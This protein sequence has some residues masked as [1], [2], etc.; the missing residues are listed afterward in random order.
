MNIAAAMAAARAA[1]AS[2][3]PRHRAV[4]RALHHLLAAVGVAQRRELARIER[5]LGL[6]ARGS[7]PQRLGRALAAALQREQRT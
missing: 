5:E 6:R 4:L 1:A 7:M 2:P 3:P